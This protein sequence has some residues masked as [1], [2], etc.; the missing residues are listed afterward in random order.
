[1][2]S[3]YSQPNNT[4]TE[5][6]FL[7]S[8]CLSSA[9]SSVKDLTMNVYLRQQWNDP[10]LRYIN[11]SSYANITHLTIDS[12]L[13][14]RMWVPDLFFPN[15]KSGHP[16]CITMP[17]RLVRIFPDGTVLYSARYGNKH[18]IVVS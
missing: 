15:E 5:V 12:K 4:S 2:T 14:E 10:R 11:Y 18:V 9:S 8:V 6:K 7:V 3:H 1:M 16:H 17:N 13:I